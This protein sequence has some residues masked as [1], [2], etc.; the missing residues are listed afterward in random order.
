M[1]NTNY[2][3]DINNND[4]DEIKNAKTFKEFVFSCLVNKKE[5]KT[6]QW[7]NMINIFISWLIITNIF[8][9]IVS[10]LESFSEYHEI[11]SLFETVSVFIFFIEYLAR[12][13]TYG[14]HKKYAN[15]WSFIAS[16]MMIFDAL[17]IFP[18]LFSFFIPN[19][20]D[21]RVLRVVRIFR[22]FRL[23]EYSDTIN[24]ITSITS[25]H[26][27]IL[28]TAFSFIL[29]A[30]VTSGSLMYFAEKDIQP[31]AFASIL[32]AIYWAIITVSTV[33]YGDIAPISD[34]G[35][36]IAGFTT[37]AGVAIYAIPTSILGAAFYA[38]MMSKESDLIDKLKIE[39]KHLVYLANDAKREMGIL[40]KLLKK[41]RQKLRNITN[42]QEGN[43]SNRLQKLLEFFK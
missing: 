22:L 37:L 21:L 11:F 19:V 8:V 18:A 12:M 9:M 34:L 1:K 2:T 13:W 4:V 38:E 26:K 10:T 16:P 28:F 31:E 30:I 36:M 35:K 23:Y 15:V 5:S 14:L 25:R 39:N 40:R 3:N 42:E 17:V 20:L 43:K 27:E 41:E 33:G 29:M 6:T 24:K 32:H 7:E